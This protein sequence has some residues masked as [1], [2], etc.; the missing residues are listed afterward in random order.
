M[1]ARVKD[2]HGSGSLLLCV[3]MVVLLVVGWFGAVGGSYAVALHRGRAAADQAALAGALAVARGQ[4]GCRS[5]ADQLEFAEASSL[6]DCRSVGDAYSYVVS[7]TV[8][9]KVATS[10]PG[11]PDALRVRAHAGPVQSRPRVP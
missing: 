8:E 2:Q 11:L 10:I 5:A 6:V 1:V 3:A 9:R 7:V 4:D